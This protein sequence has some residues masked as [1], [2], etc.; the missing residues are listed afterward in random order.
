MSNET[1]FP[2]LKLTLPSSFCQQIREF[3]DGPAPALFCGKSDLAYEF[4][5][6]L[7]EWSIRRMFAP[8]S[9]GGKFKDIIG[10][11]GEPLRYHEI[12]L[13]PPPISPTFEGHTVSNDKKR[14]SLVSTECITLINGKKL[15]STETATRDW[16]DM[17][18]VADSKPIAVYPLFR[19]LSKYKD[20]AQDSSENRKG[21]INSKNNRNGKFIKDKRVSSRGRIIKT[22]HTLDID[23][24][25][26]T[27]GNDSVDSVS[28]LSTTSR[29]KQYPKFKP[30]RPLTTAQEPEFDPND[31]DFAPL[32]ALYKAK[33]YLSAGLYSASYKSSKTTSENVRSV[34]A[35]YN[36][37]R[38]NDFIFP[39]PENYGEWLLN[40]TTDFRLP[41]DLTLWVEC[42]GGLEIVSFFI[43]I[44]IFLVSLEEISPKLQNVDKNS[45]S[46]I[47][48][49]QVQ[50][51]QIE[52]EPTPYQ[53]LRQSKFSSGFYFAIKLTFLG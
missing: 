14:K 31:P 52:R 39:L 2:I 18:T 28:S 23:D 29:R 10:W 51:M 11:K 49:I 8:H 27:N 19:K 33:G 20:I 12:S 22:P 48:Q 46:T 24:D 3:F 1:I 25:V 17:K 16:A 38:D 42:K 43:F 44:F 9:I 7:M 53:K 36:S 35:S 4:S 15:K 37:L 32:A 5:G 50:N 45:K 26:S 41:Y 40:E 13:P 34:R 47:K 21:D 30:L 6:V